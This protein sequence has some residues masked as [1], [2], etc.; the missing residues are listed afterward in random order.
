MS[1]KKHQRIAVIINSLSAG[2]AERLVADV[3]N[4]LVEAGI[5][6]DIYVNTSCESFYTLDE[7]INVSSFSTDSWFDLLLGTLKL[8]SKLSSNKS[9]C[10]WLHLW[11]TSLLSIPIRLVLLHR[12]TICITE[13]NNLYATILRRSN[14]LS[15]L[16]RILITASY[17]CSDHI[18]AVSKGLLSQVVSLLPFRKHRVVCIYNPVL[19]RF[20]KSS[21]SYAYPPKRWTDSSLKILA[22]GSL[23]EQ[24]GYKYLLH[25]ISRLDIDLHLLILGSGPLLSYL[26][27]LCVSYQITDRVTFVSA[28]QDASTFFQLADLFVS[29]SL[30]EGYGTAIAEAVAYNLPIIASNCDFGPSEILS[31]Y[32]KSKLITPADSLSLSNAIYQF[33]THSPSDSIYTSPKLPT[34]SDAASAYA[35]L[36]GLNFK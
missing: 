12:V 29:S 28:N 33:A 19:D 25:A 18:V 3:C 23:K 26:N 30:W 6:V 1:Q 7:R 8:L 24:K 17:L 9:A 2:G 35:E 14:R 5:E 20:E 27:D 16:W 31:D 10:V 36:L 22:I 32:N 11:P 34:C 15:S 21:P 4:K 13:H